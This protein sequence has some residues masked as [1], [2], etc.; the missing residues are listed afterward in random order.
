MINQIKNNLNKNLLLVIQ[1]GKK[2]DLMYKNYIRIV[3]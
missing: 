2:V 1:K 3:E